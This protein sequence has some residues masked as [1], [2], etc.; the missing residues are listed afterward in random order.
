MFHKLYI[1][2]GLAFGPFE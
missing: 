2:S 1:S